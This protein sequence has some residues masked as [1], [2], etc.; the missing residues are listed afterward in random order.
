M[1]EE[2]WSTAV[3]LWRQ[4]QATTTTIISAGPVAAAILFSSRQQIDPR[5]QWWKQW[6]ITLSI[7]FRFPDIQPFEGSYYDRVS[8]SM[9][10]PSILE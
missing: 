4:L 6:K 9:R 10:Y 5:L 2:L 7:L 3:D 8:P 1:F